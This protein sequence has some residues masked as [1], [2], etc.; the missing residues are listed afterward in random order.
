MLSKE[1]A[2]LQNE[3]DIRGIAIGG[4]EGEIVNLTDSVIYSITSSFIVWLSQVK[5][6]SAR[7]LRISIGTDSRLSGPKVKNSAINAIVNAGCHV[8]DCKMASTPAM[9]MSTVTKGYEYDGAIMVTASH[10]PFNRNGLKFFT[11]RGGLE[12][13]DI[14]R[15]L[16]ISE[17]NEFPTSKKLG[18]I[19]SVDFISVYAD[20]LVK[21]IRD[22]VNH[23]E[24]RLEPLKGFKVVVDAGNGAG[25]FFVNKVLIP[26]G[27]DVDGS[28][29][30]EPD[31]NFPNHIPNPEDKIA[32]ES[33]SKAVLQNKADIGII[34]DADVDRAGAVGGSGREINRNRLIALM[35]AIVIEEH[36]NSIIVTDSVTSTGL[37]NFIE[38]KLGGVHCRFKRGYKNV[39][40][41]GIEFN[42]EGNE[43]HLMI[44]TSGHGAL[45]ENYFLDDGAYL[46]TKILIK[47]A[48]LKQKGNK[49]IESLIVEL[50][51]PAE[52]REFRMNIKAENFKQYGSDIIS[53]LQK[54][55]V[56]EPKWHVAPDNHEGLRVSF[57]KNNGDGWLLLRMS[58][59]DPLMPLNIESDSEG[60]VKI[61]VSKLLEFL[62]RYTKLDIKSLQEFAL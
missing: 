14:T 11:N 2:K 57:D 15:I 56:N 35:A 32:I 29:F 44:E 50:D 9:F 54:Y 52:S 60:G 5:Q 51:E 48:K 46:V 39:I 3:S 55:A 13:K 61:I 59:H 21:K 7:E 38:G 33:I 25:G 20:I 10:L 26:L 45:R 18:Q 27:A 36:P 12:K 31:G 58:L 24:H 16:E 41:K 30:I 47:M 49:T 43:C 62:C 6:I 53:D 42:N 40:N 4:I 23:T 8:Y 1:W 17:A 28:Q 37:K 22:E 19:S 34:F